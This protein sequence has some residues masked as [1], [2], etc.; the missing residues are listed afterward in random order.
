M[1]NSYVKLPE[2]NAYR[3]LHYKRSSDMICSFRGQPSA[4]PV[5]SGGFGQRERWT[6]SKLY[7]L[8]I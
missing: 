6:N 4:Q 1:F 3:N 2:G 7:P 5:L 8:V